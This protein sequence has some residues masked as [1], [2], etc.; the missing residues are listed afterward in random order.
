MRAYR[1]AQ[2][3][4]LVAASGLRATPNTS[5]RQDRGLH[6][7]VRGHAEQIGPV[8]SLLEKY[9]DQEMDYTDVCIVR[10]S[11]LFPECT[12]FSVDSDFKVY[13]RFRDREIPTVYPP[14]LK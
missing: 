13:R 5:Q 11:E 10:L 6:T 9:K 14:D 4:R 1:I 3:D 8:R 2:P 12:V 7:D